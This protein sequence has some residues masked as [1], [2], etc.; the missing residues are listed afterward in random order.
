MR[1]LH[2][3]CIAL[4][5]VALVAAVAS[6]AAAAPS[7]AP[8]WPRISGPAGAGAQL[9]LARTTDG[10]LHV[11][12]NRGATSTAIFD[13]RLSP[14]GAPIGTSAVASGWDGNGGLALLQMP[15]RTLRLFA[16]GGHAPGLASALVGMNT[17]T[18]PAVGSKWTLASGVVWGGAVANAAANIGATLTKDGEPV[19]AWAG[20][21]HKGLDPGAASIPYHADMGTSMLATDQA[22]GAVVL[23]GETIAGQ[24]GTF[25][26]QVLPTKGPAVLLPS[27]LQ[28][29]SSGLA[30][31]IG[32]PGVYVAYADSHAVKLYRYGGATKTLATGPY[33]TTAVFSGPEGRL[34]VVWGDPHGIFVTRSN[35]SVSGFEPVQKLAL[36]A[37]T[38]SL[39]HVEGEG[40]AGPLDLFTDVLLGADDRGYRHAHVLAQFALRAQAAKGKVTL[41][42]A[43]AGD[44]LAGVAIVV[45]GKHLRTD[46]HG[47]AVA[48]LR[49]GS[50]TATATATGYTPASARLT[51]R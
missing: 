34:W 46:A 37:N 4:A 48:V 10:V 8:A 26:Q 43:D 27:A 41:S 44:P 22:T 50:Y 51:V 38:T 24:G 9:G 17:L 1:T 30:A 25:V 14:I 3:P 45:A 36:P 13:T 16:A 11:I 12:W 42:A 6:L 47:R 49:L 39:Y 23:A 35:R 40:S 7:A 29:R 2:R 19:T 21:V 20:T 28:E 5:A 18:A 33:D 32:A 31:R 15:D